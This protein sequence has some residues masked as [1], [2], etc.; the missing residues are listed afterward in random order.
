MNVITLN[1]I[2]WSIIFTMAYVLTK[3]NEKYNFMK[4][5]QMKELEK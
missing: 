5:P 2:K 3:L 4:E 1:V